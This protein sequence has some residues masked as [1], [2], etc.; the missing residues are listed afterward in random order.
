MVMNL[1]HE[2]YPAAAILGQRFSARRPWPSHFSHSQPISF[3]R[4]SASTTNWRMA[5]ARLITA[6]NTTNLSRRELMTTSVGLVT[7]NVAA[8]AI[9]AG[10]CSG[11]GVGG[12]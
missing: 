10:D 9:A 11:H 4:F 3:R 6:C 8:A 1:Y 12:R 2:L 7:A 5:A